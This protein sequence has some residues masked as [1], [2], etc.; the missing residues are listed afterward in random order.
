AQHLHQRV[1]RIH[2]P[3]VRVTKKSPLLNAV[4]EVPVATFRFHLFANVDEHMDRVSVRPFVR[5]HFRRGHQE[6]AIRQ[7]FDWSFDAPRLVRAKGAT[8]GD[9]FPLGPKH[10]VDRAPDQPGWMNSKSRG[11]RTINSNNISIRVVNDNR[12]RNRINY[13]DPPLPGTMH[14]FKQARGF[15]QAGETYSEE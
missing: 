3:P 6:A 8:S 9:F 12:V 2:H 5:G 11:K 13:P 7:K 10:F 4:E 1:I 15:E 14:L